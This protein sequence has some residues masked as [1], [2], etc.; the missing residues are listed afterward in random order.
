MQMRFGIPTVLCTVL[1]DC[2]QDVMQ[3]VIGKALQQYESPTGV[4]E[5]RSCVRYAVHT[6]G[7]P[8]VAAFTVTAAILSLVVVWPWLCAVSTPSLW[9]HLQ[10]FAWTDGNLGAVA[11]AQHDAAA[12]ADIDR[13]RSPWPGSAK[14]LAFISHARSPRT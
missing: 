11:A 3:A 4:K 9:E 2:T 14:L 12:T 6:V 5:L 8:L 10:R 13:V 1:Y 7:N